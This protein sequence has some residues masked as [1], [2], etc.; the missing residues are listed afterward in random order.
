MKLDTKAV[1]SII[2]TYAIPA[3][4]LALAAYA[5]NASALIKV[6]SFASGVVAIAIRQAN[7]KD[8]FTVKLLTFVKAEIDSTID[9]Q[10][11]KA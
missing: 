6:L 8:P 3:V 1:K 9:N 2:L 4:P 5:L 7:P 11:P 10:T